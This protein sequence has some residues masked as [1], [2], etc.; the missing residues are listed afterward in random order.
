MKLEKI[1]SYDVHPA[2]SLF[3]LM[4]EPELEQL[5]AD[6]RA[7]GQLQA[8]ELFGGKVLDG[9]NRLLVC[10]RLGV[11]PRITSWAPGANG[12]ISPT[13]H[14]MSLNVRRRHLAP[15][16]LAMIAAEALP[17]FEAEAKDRQRAAGG[18]RKSVSAKSRQAMPGACGMKDGGAP[19]IHDAGHSGAHSNGLRTWKNKAPSPVESGKAARHAAAATGVG[20]RQVELAKQLRRDSPAL[21]E[22]VKSGELTLNRASKTVKKSRQLTQIAAYRPPEGAFEVIS[23]DPPWPF[24]DQ[25]DGS[26]DARG[27]LPY[28]AMTIDQIA[29]VKPP[30]DKDCVLWL[31]TTNSH[32]V[33]LRAPVQQVLK[34]WGFTPKTLLTWKKDR[35]GVGRYLRNIT[36]HCVL[37][38][39]GNP[40]LNLTNETTFIAAVRRMHS[41]KPA[42][43][44]EMVE[45]LCPGR[46]RL[47]MY[48]RA[49]RDGWV[50]SGPEAPKQARPSSIAPGD[51]AADAVHE[52]REKLLAG[53]PVPPRAKKPPLHKRCSVK[54]CKTETAS[55]LCD[56]HQGLAT[57]AQRE[58]ERT[59]AANPTAGFEAGSAEQVTASLEAYRRGEDVCSHCGITRARNNPEKGG[60]GWV[61]AGSREGTV[62]LPLCF[63]CNRAGVAPSYVITPEDFEKWKAAL[64]SRSAGRSRIGGKPPKRP[65][66]KPGLRGALARTAVDG[67]TP[68]ARFAFFGSRGRRGS[69]R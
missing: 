16:Q 48:A 67:P 40:L 7:N 65:K 3:P 8:I 25:L 50:T 47:E 61:H 26:D 57:L 24:E 68:T 20:A 30:A 42:E 33:D 55:A 21:A 69:T 22:K 51:A 6:I 17:L 36:E 29:A 56:Q 2:A 31:W 43:F 1:G 19:C 54:G 66:K 49:A 41:E 63:D 59:N 27:G 58:Y 64:G 13:A 53:L 37:A 52:A 11:K 15:S 60:C 34:G 62:A 10:E 39:R 44:Y 28:P 23:A 9:R 18:D 46:S 12:E 45:K 5:G 14:V 35:M 38:I 4:T 32:L